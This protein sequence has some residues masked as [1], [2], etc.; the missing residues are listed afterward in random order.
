MSEQQVR[1][2]KIYLSKY[3]ISLKDKMIIDDYE[4]M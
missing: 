3:T 1:I 4:Y 2:K